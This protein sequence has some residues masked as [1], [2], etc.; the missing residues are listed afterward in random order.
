[1]YRYN[2][3]YGKKKM[4]SRGIFWFLVLRIQSVNYN[5]NAHVYM[6]FEVRSNLVSKS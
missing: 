3:G 6:D 1:V 5:F 2:V 4:S